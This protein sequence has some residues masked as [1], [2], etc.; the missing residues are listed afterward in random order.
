MLRH[1]LLSVVALVGVNLLPAAPA[2]AD[3]CSDLSFASAAEEAYVQNVT[4]VTWGVTCLEAR[5]VYRNYP[6]LKENTPHHITWSATAFEPS[7][8]AIAGAALPVPVQSCRVT[9]TARVRNLFGATLVSVSMSQWW[10]YNG[11]RVWPEAPRIVP[12]TGSG[13]P[14]IIYSWDG[15]VTD[16]DWYTGN[17]VSPYYTHSTERFGKFSGTAG[18]FGSF[19]TNPRML[20]SKQANGD[21][22]TLN[23]WGLAGCED[24]D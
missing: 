22:A 20:I 3:A 18:P 9:T 2:H 15:I 7:D 17:S 16:N 6:S 8:V 5:N 11:T 10:D 24:D 12:N 21:W 23:D 19:G 4:A 13:V 1:V 14:S